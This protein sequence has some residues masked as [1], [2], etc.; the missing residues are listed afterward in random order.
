MTWTTRAFIGPNAITQ[1]VSFH[2]VKPNTVAVLLI[3]PH[4]SASAIER[5]HQTVYGQTKPQIL[6]GAVVDSLYGRDTPAWT[7]STSDR[8]KQATGFH[9][10]RPRLVSHRSVGRWPDST[11]RNGWFESSDPHRSNSLFESL[12]QPPMQSDL[13]PK[14]LVE[15]KDYYG[16]KQGSK[17]VMMMLTDDEPLQTIRSLND[18]FP[19][20]LKVGL[21]ASR[22]PFLNG[23][24]FTL[25]SN[26]AVVN[27]GSVGLCWNQPDDTLSADIDQSDYKPISGSLVISK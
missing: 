22:T 15:C 17:P 23:K 8:L 26:D 4:F 20:A 18:A 14:H 13:L 16:Y 19:E 10:Q 6:V 2:P 12:S 5:L 9:I 24:P 1:S 21:V 11:S 3:T 27:S 25:F 7:L